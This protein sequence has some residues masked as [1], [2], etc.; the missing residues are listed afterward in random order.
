MSFYIRGF[1]NTSSY[2]C[3]TNWWPGCI[4]NLPLYDTLYIIDLQC[5]FS[6]GVM[7]SSLIQ[8]STISAKINK[9][10]IKGNCWAWNGFVYGYFAFAKFALFMIYLLTCNCQTS[11]IITLSE[12]KDKLTSS[13]SKS[14]RRQKIA[15]C[16]FCQLN[17]NQLQWWFSFSYI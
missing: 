13:T 14:Y 6:V 1:I 16:L 5:T 11:K 10:Q 15:A 2:S 7:V 17:S 9:P 12:L 3:S 8:I 4:Y